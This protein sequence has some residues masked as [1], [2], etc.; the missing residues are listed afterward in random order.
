MSIDC[1]DVCPTKLRSS[2]LRYEMYVLERKIHFSNRTEREWWATPVDVELQL[3]A[4]RYDG[5]SNDAENT[6]RRATRRLLDEKAS[7]G[8]DSEIRRPS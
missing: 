2:G 6:T 8:S 1:S 7:P 4:R 3:D 5:F